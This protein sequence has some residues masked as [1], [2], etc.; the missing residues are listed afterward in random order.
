MS[1]SGKTA[2]APLWKVLK[3]KVG[4]LFLICSQILQLDNLELRK[5]TTGRE[6]FD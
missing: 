4:W 3:E 2:K 6:K 5:L 1:I